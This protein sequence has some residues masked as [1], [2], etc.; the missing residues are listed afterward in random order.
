MTTFAG[1]LLHIGVQFRSN[2]K[3]Q[4]VGV[5]EDERARPL[6]DNID[7]AEPAKLAFS[8]SQFCKASTISR[9]MLYTLW[10]RNQGPPRITIG[11]RVL[12]PYEGGKA[13]LHNQF[14]A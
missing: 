10:E 6:P 3:Y 7:H 11:G 5:T 1:T 4:G 8:I 13:W 14:A 12:I 2:T 9:R